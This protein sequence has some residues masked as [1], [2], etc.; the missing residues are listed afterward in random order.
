VVVDDAGVTLAVVVVIVVVV[1][2]D[3]DVDDVTGDIVVVDEQGQFSPGPDPTASA[4]HTNASDAVMG[5]APVGA[6][7][8]SGMHVCVPTAAWRM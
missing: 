2:V 6:Q 1:V 3:I 4:R 8:H 5:S 7:I